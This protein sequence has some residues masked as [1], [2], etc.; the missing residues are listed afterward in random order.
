MRNESIGRVGWV[1]IFGEFDFSKKAVIYF[2]GKRILLPAPG[3]PPG[4][5]DKE[6]PSLGL[7]LGSKSIFDGKLTA[8]VEF[9]KVTKDSS[10]E[11]VVSYNPN[12]QHLIA[13]G[14][15]GEPFA[16]FSIREFG[17]PRTSGPAWS[18]YI[19]AG[20][21]SALHPRE[22]Y[23][24]EARFYGAT[25][26]LLINGVSIGTSEVT[27]PMGRSRQVGLLCRAD[28]LITVRDFNV[29]SIKPKVFIVM[30]L[31]NDYE[32][33]FKDVVK[34]VCKDYEVNPLRADEVAGPGL[35]IA[36]IAREISSA[37]LVI[38][39]IT[40]INPNVYF[41]VGYSIALRKPMILLA[42]KGTALPFDVAGFRVLF[43]EDTIG[44]KKRLEEGLRKHLDAILNS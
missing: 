20:D 40:P 22:S 3:K 2:K 12:P 29:D 33:I 28:H 26:N 32:D 10:C 1:P 24:L 38:A 31:G 15:G 14:L 6:Q 37:Q 13:A 44:G 19:V 16:F 25:V 42:K 23:H 36:D 18:N 35:I 9:E 43:Y 4:V 7:L 17:G 39:D 21:R 41:E 34:E 27:S 11:L 5:E 8:K 30:Q